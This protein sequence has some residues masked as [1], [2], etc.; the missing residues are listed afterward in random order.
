M[1]VFSQEPKPNTPSVPNY[2]QKKNHTY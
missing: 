1:Y 2:K